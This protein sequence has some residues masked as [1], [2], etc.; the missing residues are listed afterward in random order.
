MIAT[1]TKGVWCVVY[2]GAPYGENELGE[3]VSRHRTEEAA[4][5]ARVKLQ[6]NPKYYGSNSRVEFREAK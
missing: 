1:T 5:A 3:V 4:T 6:D 2:C